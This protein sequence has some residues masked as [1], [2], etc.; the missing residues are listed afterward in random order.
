MKALV[1]YAVG[2]VLDFF[3]ER[4]TAEDFA[5][6]RVRRVLVSP[7]LDAASMAVLRRM[8]PG[9]EFRSCDR[10]T[11]LWRVRMARFAAACIPM[12]GGDLRGRMIGLL[13][14]A[15]HKLL[16]PSAD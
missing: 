11:N 5:G 8:F 10:R 3:R 15:R 4:V 7:G 13:S 1:R 6:E 14:G 16:L 12:A 9:A 2:Y